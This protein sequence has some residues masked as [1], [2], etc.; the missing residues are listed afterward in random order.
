MKTNKGL[1]IGLAAAGVAI[2]GIVV[3][4]TTT[5]TG[6]ETMKKLG[7]KGKKFAVQ[8]EEIIKGAK[9]KID[10]LK[11]EFASKD[12]EPVTQAYE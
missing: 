4:L 10:N 3:F 11:E 2:A 8:A 7:V 9:K 12:G 1:I 6:K 5:K